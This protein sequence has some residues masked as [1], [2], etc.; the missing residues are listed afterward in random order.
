VVRV[1]LRLDALGRLRGRPWGGRVSRVLREI[2]APLV[3]AAPAG[4]R[5]RTRLRVYV[6]D[7]EVL[8]AVGHHLGS[9][10][11]RDLAARCA[12]GRLDANARC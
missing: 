11:G 2:A 9:L 7:A 10:A 12:E 6:R 4:V 1:G 8:T 3:V 5:V